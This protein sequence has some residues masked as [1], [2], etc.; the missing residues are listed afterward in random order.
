MHL[1]CQL[2]AGWVRLKDMAARVKFPCETRAAKWRNCL[3]S[4]VVLVFGHQRILARRKWS[5]LAD[6][7]FWSDH[8]FGI[9]S[10]L[11]LDPTKKHLVSQKKLHGT[12][13]QRKEARPRME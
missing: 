2:S 12:S 3:S 13:R 7:E 6:D 5:A 11:I 4:I 8:L 10:A 1:I 9:A